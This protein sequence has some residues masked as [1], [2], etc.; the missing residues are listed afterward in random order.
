MNKL[1]DFLVRP[2]RRG[3]QTAD[4]GPPYFKTKYG[5]CTRKDFDV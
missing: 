4:L 3:Y 5:Y 1:T 2:R